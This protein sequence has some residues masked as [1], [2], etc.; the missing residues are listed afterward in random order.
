[1]LR[2]NHMKRNLTL[3]IILFCFYSIGSAQTE[4]AKAQSMFVYNFS[5]LI[6]WPV[7]N[8]TGVFVIGVVGNSAIYGELSSYTASKK[9]G[10]QSIEVVKYNDAE[11]VDKCHI[12]FVPFNKTSKMEEIVAKVG[13]N[14][15]LIICEKKGALEAGAAINFVVIGNSLKFELNSANATGKGLKVSSSLQNMAVNN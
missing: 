6:E 1:M 15:T 4:I 10:A 12:L 11:N 8:Q 13:G 14:N 7:A 3:I 9:V 5:R 2:H